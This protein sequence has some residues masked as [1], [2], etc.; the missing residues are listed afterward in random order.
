MYTTRQRNPISNEF[1]SLPSNLNMSLSNS[2]LPHS[3]QCILQIFILLQSP[4][5]PYSSHYQ[6]VTFKCS[7][8]NMIEARNYLNQT[9]KPACNLAQ[10]FSFLMSLS[11]QGPPLHLYHPLSFYLR[12]ILPLCSPFL[13][14]SS[15]I[16]PFYS[17][18][19]IITYKH[20]SIP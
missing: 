19:P 18:L 15:L 10:L 2:S 12:D 13:I 4:T 6:Q 9:C 5:F 17:F 1:S 16:C 7:F 8:T 3:F 11:Y 20:V 14:I